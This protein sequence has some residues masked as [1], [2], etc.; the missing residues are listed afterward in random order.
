MTA[1]ASGCSSADESEVAE[2]ANLTSVRPTDETRPE[3]SYING[4]SIGGEEF[5]PYKEAEP[6]Y[7]NKVQ[8]GFEAGS[9]P[10]RKCMAEGMRALARIL[11][12]PPQSLLQLREK[13]GIDSFF[14]W[15]NDYTGAPRDGMGRFRRIWLYESSLIKWI[16]ETNKDGT[17]MIQTKEDLDR[18]ATRCLDTFPNC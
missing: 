18:F 11:Q 8:W 3:E 5:W 17:C 13:H 15:N 2:D 9:E 10:A 12:D 4:F 14:Q 1:L 7:P 6:I 16:S